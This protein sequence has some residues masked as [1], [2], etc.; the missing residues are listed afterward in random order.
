MNEILGIIFWVIRDEEEAFR[1][2]CIIMG[3]W[4]D[5]FQKQLDKTMMGIKY[6]M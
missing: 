6:Q 2:F 3:E 5:L 4:R 1:I